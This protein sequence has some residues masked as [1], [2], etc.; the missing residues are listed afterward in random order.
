MQS[1]SVVDKYDVQ[2]GK[3]IFKQKFRD[4]AAH[5]GTC[6]R[7]RIVVNAIVWEIREFLSKIGLGGSQN[8]TK[9]KAYR[10]QTHPSHRCTR[11]SRHTRPTREYTSRKHSETLPA[12][13]HLLLAGGK[14]KHA[15][16]DDVTREIQDNWLDIHTHDCRHTA[17]KRE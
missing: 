12:R 3:K 6:M 14:E 2:H 9:I 7:S 4:Y 17:L 10:S 5:R 1:R 11:D 8:D 15:H 13:N 16:E